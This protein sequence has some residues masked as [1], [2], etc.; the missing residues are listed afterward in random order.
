VPTPSTI[1]V[2]KATGVNLYIICSA[3]A[4]CIMDCSS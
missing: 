2:N 3:N 4:N 1:L